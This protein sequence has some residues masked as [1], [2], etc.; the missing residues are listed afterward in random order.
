MRATRGCLQRQRRRPVRGIGGSPLSS[1]D[2]IVKAINLS[3]QIQ[4]GSTLTKLY[5]TGCTDYANSNTCRVANITTTKPGLFLTADPDT[6]EL[7]IGLQFTNTAQTSLKS[8]PLQQVAGQPEHTLAAQP[9]IINNGE[10]SLKTTSGFQ[11]ADT[12]DAWLLTHGIRH[13][14]DAVQVSGG[15]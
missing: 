5:L 9:L 10:V 8:L 3:P 1:S 15:N 13:P 6:Q 12:A 4:P 14:L 11:P 2:I 7:R